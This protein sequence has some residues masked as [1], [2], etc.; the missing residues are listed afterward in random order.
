MQLK[1]L[2]FLEGRI[3]MKLL[4][5]LAE[6]DKTL[7]QMVIENQKVRAEIAKG[8]Y[9]KERLE[10]R[11]EDFDAKILGILERR[12]DI[13]DLLKAKEPDMLEQY[14]RTG[15]AGTMPRLLQGE[16]TVF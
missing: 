2:Y 8:P 13:I 11:W 5:E 3:I 4:L 15:E 16:A 10:A 9:K 12:V 14:K 1:R 7:Y 6:I